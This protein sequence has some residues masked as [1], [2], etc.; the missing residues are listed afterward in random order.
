MLALV[1]RLLEDLD[2]LLGLQGCEIARLMADRDRLSAIC[3]LSFAL[4]NRQDTKLSR[5]HKDCA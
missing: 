3:F 1:S 2:R 4:L 5:L